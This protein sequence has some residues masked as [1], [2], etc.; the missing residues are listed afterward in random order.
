MTRKEADMNKWT[1]CALTLAV[2]ALPMAASAGGFEL[3]A[4]A[5]YAEPDGEIAY[6]PN[7]ANRFIDLRDEAGFDDE[8]QLLVRA[9]LQPP[10]LPGLYLQATP[11]SFESSGSSS[12]EFSF[13]DAVFGAGEEIDSDFFLNMY[14]AVL[15]VP[16]P[17]IKQ[18]D[19]DVFSVEL[20]AGAKWFH[21]RA[22]LENRSID[23]DGLEELIDTSALEDSQRATVVY[24]QGYAAVH[25]KPHERVTLEGEFWGWSN[26]G[27]KFWTL[28]ARLKLRVAGPLYVDGGYRFDRV[29]ID[30]DD[31][32]IRDTD[33]SGPFTEV[34]LAW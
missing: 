34:G 28:L 32:S 21:I 9:K 13:G 26:N 18:G 8:W 15:Y 10:K 6:S 4:G 12:F 22:E 27:D 29:D 25:I 2:L 17:L 20:G 24:P 14:D 33:L 11:L 5:W 30:D 31:L 19:L 7:G 16:I 23:D 3:S 1:I